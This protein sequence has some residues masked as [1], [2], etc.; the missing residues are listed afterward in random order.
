M[1]VLE[2]TFPT[3]GPYRF[4]EA[5][6]G[7][8]ETLTPMKW[9]TTLED[10]ENVNAESVRYDSSGVTLSCPL[11]RS[12]FDPEGGFRGGRL[13][14]PG[15]IP[16]TEWFV[17]C[18]EEGG[19]GLS[20]EASFGSSVSATEDHPINWAPGISLTTSDW[21]HVQPP[22]L[23]RKGFKCSA[24]QAMGEAVVWCNLAQLGE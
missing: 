6:K 22:N 14:L 16:G 17:S 21:S 19:E 11:G 23:G 1:P 4:C 5:T 10:F 24:K 13:Y 7:A 12:F 18:A 15:N 3:P 2:L 8:G 9:P 20:C